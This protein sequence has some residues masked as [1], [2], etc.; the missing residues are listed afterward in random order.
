MTDLEQACAD[1][2][3]QR[4][5]HFVKTIDNRQVLSVPKDKGSKKIPWLWAYELDGKAIGPIRA[6][7]AR[8]SHSDC[9]QENLF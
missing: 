1:L 7:D 4:T 2:K 8:S 3:K 9:R 5:R 6:G